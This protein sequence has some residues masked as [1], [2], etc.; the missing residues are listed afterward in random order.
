MT[1]HTLHVGENTRRNQS[2]KFEIKL[3]QKRIAFLVVSSRRVYHFER[4]NSAPGRNAASTNP[5]KNRVA[6]MPEN[7][8]VM[9]DNVDIIPQSNITTP[10]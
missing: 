1:E 3:P 8:V 9:P 7:P 10:I 5:R 2:R 6:T 4:I